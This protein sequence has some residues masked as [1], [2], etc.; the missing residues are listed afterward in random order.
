M[1]DKKTSKKI[2]RTPAFQKKF[3]NGKKQSI[4]N[5]LKVDFVDYKNIKLLSK[6]I[7][8]FERIL[9]SRITGHKH[10]HQRM[11]NRAVKRARFMALLPYC[12]GHNSIKGERKF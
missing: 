11:L 4:L 1:S 7:S 3:Q 2:S 6:Y 9:P 8:V 12:V 5:A 10:K